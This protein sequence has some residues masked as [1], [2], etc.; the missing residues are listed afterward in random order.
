MKMVRY[1][2][3]YARYEDSHPGFW[4]KIRTQRILEMLN[5]RNG[6]RVLEVGCNTGWLVRELRRYSDN[7]IGIDVNFA[8]L[9][10]GNT[11]NLICMDATNMAFPNSS[12][13]K[14]VCLHTIEHI[15]RVDMALDEMSRILKPEGS[16][17]LVYP[18]EIIRGMFAVGG[19]L[20]MCSSI[21][22]A[23]ELH[24]H[25]LYPGKISKMIAGNGLRPK[26]SIMF[27]DPWPAFLTVLEKKETL[28]K[29][30][31]LDVQYPKST[32]YVWTRNRYAESP[33]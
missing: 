11:Q 16:I 27:L 32:Q 33:A 22:K 18:F 15:P 6:D 25:K 24:L 23:R 8:G 28:E 19:A 3:T 20:A 14:I 5:M 17:V 12:F 1:D 29:D 7:V 2:E 31:D 4:S 9:K 30:F 26:G 10:I 21:A 13:D